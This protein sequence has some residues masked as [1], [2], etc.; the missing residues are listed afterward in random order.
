MICPRCKKQV[1]DSAHSCPFC[2]MLLK[3]EKEGKGISG[4]FKE[5]MFNDGNY[6]DA[7]I[8]P[9]SDAAVV[10]SVNENND[11]QEGNPASK[12]YTEA[13]VMMVLTFIDRILVFMFIGFLFFAFVRDVFYYVAFVAA[14][15][16]TVIYSFSIFRI[17]KCP[18]CGEEL[19]GFPENNALTCKSCK[20][21]VIV[22]NEHF[23]KVGG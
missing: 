2:N 21:R 13:L 8:R 16:A 7:E 22:K 5:I 1:S 18:Y 10:E 9:T 3:F 23:H 15:T 12:N 19:K 20:N 11:G 14:M 4:F 6:R 17:G